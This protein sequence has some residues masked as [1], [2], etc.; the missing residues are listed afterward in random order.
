MEYEV[1]PAPICPACAASHTLVKEARELIFT[2]RGQT[3]AF[4]GQRLLRLLIL[5]IG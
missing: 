5:M 3:V 2:Y 1:V 4:S